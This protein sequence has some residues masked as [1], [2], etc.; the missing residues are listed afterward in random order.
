MAHFQ[1]FC[2]AFV[3]FQSHRIWNVVIL[4]QLSRLAA[5]YDVLVVSMESVG[6]FFELLFA[7]VFVAE[8]EKL[9]G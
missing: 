8:V 4:D 7:F 6:D 3:V 5:L 1:K 9:C 2:G